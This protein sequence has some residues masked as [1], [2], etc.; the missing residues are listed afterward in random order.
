MNEDVPAAFEAVRLWRSIR[1]AVAVLHLAASESRAHAIARILRTLEPGWEVLELPPWDC[2]P[3]D[4]VSPSVATMGRRMAVLAKL[5]EPA[6][7][8][9]LVL[10]SPL[11][12][13]QRLPPVGAARHLTLCTGEPLDPEQL[14]ETAASLGYRID[15]RVDEP[16]E[17]AL[18]GGAIDV[19]PSASDEPMR[20]EIEHGAIAAIRRYDAATQLS[21]GED[22]G[23]LVLSPATELPEPPDAGQR[24]AEHRMAEAWPA[25]ATLVDHLGP[26]RVTVGIGGEDAVQAALDA[27]DDALAERRRE[28][29]GQPPAPSAP[30]YLD[31]AWW[32]A[33]QREPLEAE[34]YSPLPPLAEARRPR[35]AL[36]A[37]LREQSGMGR[38]IVL[39]APTARLAEQMARRAIDP[40]ADG[41]AAPLA[42]SEA[43][44]APGGRPVL[45][46]A[47]LDRGFVD[48]RD[49]LAVLTAQ[50]L[51]GSRAATDDA[52][53]SD[54]PWAWEA[55]ELHLGDIVVHEEHGVACLEGL[56]RVP[57]LA[58]GEAIRLRF[59]GGA[60]LL[61]PT[62]EAG[63]IWRYGGPDSGVPLDSLGSRN[64]SRRR[65]KMDAALAAAARTILAAAAERA[66]RSA[67][68]FH[69]DR[70]RY[71]R[72][73]RR[74]PF[75]LTPDQSAAIRDVL[76]DLSS[77]RP[78]D[79]V[80][81]GDVGY[82]KTEVAI[83]AAGA[84]ALAG[85]QVALIAP[86]TV[87][88]RQHFETVRR[89]FAGLGVEVAH[90]S[91]LVPLREA[92]KV[93]Q[94][95]A[96]GSIRIV[97][98]TH[99][100]L[101]RAVRFD[102]LA[103]VIVD[104]EQRLGAAQKR[105][106]RDTVR[107][108]HVLAMS[109]TPIPK[110]LQS[111]L[112]GLQDLSVIATAP[113]RRRPIRTVLGVDRDDT[114]RSALRR[115]ARRGGQSFVVIPRV[116][117][118]AATAERLQRLV[119]ELTVVVAHGG[120][121]PRDID[122][123]MVAFAEGRGDVL[124]ATSIIESGLDVPRANTMVV[125]RPELFGLAQLHQL[126][127]RV[128]RGAAQ[129]FC[130]LLPAETDS[131]DEGAL[132]RLETL[133]TLDR[134]GAGMAISARDLDLRGAGEIG[135]L[136][137]SGHAALLGLPL[138]QELLAA[139]LRAARGEPSGLQEVDYL[140]AEG[141]TLPDEYIPE[142]AQRLNVY[143]R[144]ARAR[145]PADARRLAEEVID[146]FGTPPPEAERLL[147]I[148]LAKATARQ[149]GITRISAGP[150]AIAFDFADAEAQK[151]RIEDALSA[152]PDL[153]WTGQRL[154]WHRAEADGA[155]RER[156]VLDL[157]DELA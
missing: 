120:M 126:R 33:L 150:E 151:E 74:F 27:I 144:L 156:L 154:V 119:P 34:G 125:L 102:D 115:E 146:R 18:R 118:A 69:P 153:A 15:D 152:L 29:E 37:F 121:A 89:R 67:R 40:P 111:A 86:T 25:L 137:Q 66:A 54:L 26:C 28:R 78:M 7:G 92:K 129:A 55:A 63:A 5:A 43:A 35:A 2:L 110:T 36:S 139:A 16:G 30:L 136:R 8:P 77:G 82:G 48:E 19:F 108:V 44:T 97:V 143:V 23:I 105:R 130:Y 76:R 72:L 106:L 3:F 70:A 41:V 91:R 73:C 49:G 138:M 98:G 20:I 99:A 147:R 14:R 141:G 53:R 58:G 24:G 45:T 157:L 148:A 42:W 1:N 11:G 38:R 93:R 155:A 80:V 68:K 142:A 65:K 96:D 132:R 62:G 71:E 100:V 10:T 84:V 133:Q 17:I 95:L 9:R 50:D 104:E 94:G 51:L 140:G 107:G 88:A 83:R 113:A 56:E 127:G 114:V 101:G 135:G 117:D 109:A 134:L 22:E 116:E 13:L 131:L 81:I 39:A 6:E 123:A 112:S 32:D 52:R 60:A 149:L 46:L 128:G 59:A 47:S 4:W 64:W 87:L 31:R 61:V 90:L 124:L 79:R 21:I 85:G 75:S 12:L 145:D 57:D 103:L 122:T